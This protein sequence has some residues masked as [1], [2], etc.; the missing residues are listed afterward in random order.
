MAK[1]PHARAKKSRVSRDQKRQRFLFSRGGL[2]PFQPGKPFAPTSLCGN[3]EGGSSWVPPGPFWLRR[4]LSCSDNKETGLCD[5]LTLMTRASPTN[6]ENN[7]F[8]SYLRYALC[9]FQTELEMIHK[10]VL[11]LLLIFGEIKKRS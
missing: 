10:K 8:I 5:Q 7:C 11:Q 9:D 1:C 4:L 6:H 2:P 3:Q